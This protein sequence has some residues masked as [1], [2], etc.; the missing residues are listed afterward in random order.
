MN[1]LRHEWYQSESQVTVSILAKHIT[2]NDVT[3]DSKE[4]TVIFLNFI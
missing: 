1:I 3:I 4:N 2:S